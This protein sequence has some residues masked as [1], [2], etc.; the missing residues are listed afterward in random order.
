MI[1]LGISGMVGDVASHWGRH[2]HH[3]VYQCLSSYAFLQTTC[4]V[5]ISLTSNII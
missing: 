3:S 5:Y 1:D 2:N 4:L